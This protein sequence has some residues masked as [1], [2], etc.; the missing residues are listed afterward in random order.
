MDTEPTP[1]PAE[2]RQADRS[3]EI[4]KLAEALSK[5]QASLAEAQK[6]SSANAGRFSYD[7]A[8]LTEIWRVARP[9]LAANGLAVV[10][11]FERLDSGTCLVTTLTHASGQFVAS[12]LPLMKVSDY[13]ALGSA[14]TYSRRYSLAAIVGI[15]PQGEDDD[16]AAAMKKPN[17][18]PATKPEAQAKERDNGRPR[19]RATTESSTTT[20]EPAHDLDDEATRIAKLVP[21]C[22]NF[23]RSNS[24]W[25]DVG[26]CVKP[27]ARANVISQGEAGMATVINKQNKEDSEQ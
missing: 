15:A 8:D 20:I 9:A 12:R 25:D 26:Q 22:V 3:A 16:G 13:H 14:I 10:Q 24:A 7:Y 27:F 2:V 5:A 21:G 4:H 1:P 17:A 11:T 18:P 6:N 23:L 19:A